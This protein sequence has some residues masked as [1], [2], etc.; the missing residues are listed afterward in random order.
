ME[1]SAVP[2]FV[3]LW[4]PNKR[5]NTVERNELLPR[6]NHYTRAMELLREDS[7]V[8][9]DF[10]V[11]MSL[12]QLV[13]QLKPI[14][15]RLP[16]F[17]LIGHGQPETG[18]MSMWNGDLL[19]PD[20]LLKLWSCG[21][22]CDLVATA[23]GANLFCSPMQYPILLHFNRQCRFLAAAEPTS[24][25]SHS[26]NT[27]PQ[28]YHLE[29][30]Q[31]MMHYLAVY[32]Q[33]GD[34]AAVTQTD[35]FVKKYRRTAKQRQREKQ[36][37]VLAEEKNKIIKQAH[38]KM[39]AHHAECTAFKTRCLERAAQTQGLCAHRTQLAAWTS[40]WW[41]VFCIFLILQ[42]IDVV[43]LQGP[44]LFYALLDCAIYY[45]VFRQ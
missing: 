31:L 28:Q 21:F 30:T 32:G 9:Y 18:A 10:V 41:T 17:V 11:A 22:Q 2:H 26:F 44:L 19:S 39:L 38:A 13:R 7:P 4:I 6:L 25:M 14:P 40:R 12:D 16:V 29:L 36:Q 42:L 5:E 33:A 43:G 35:A 37:C 15:D 45:F 27:G 24:E 3:F 1:S 34:H 8:V 20:T 23:C